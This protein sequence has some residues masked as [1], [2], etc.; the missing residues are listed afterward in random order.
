MT[1]PTITV[2]QWSLL[3]EWTMRAILE[4]EANIIECPEDYGPEALAEVNKKLNEVMAV[5]RTLDAGATQI[6]LEKAA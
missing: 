2:R 4:E 1:L 3:R 5:I 6:I